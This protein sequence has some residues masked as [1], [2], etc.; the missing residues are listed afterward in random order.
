VGVGGRCVGV[1][2]LRRL[3]TPVVH[4]KWYL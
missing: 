3:R 4:T 1:G 2:G